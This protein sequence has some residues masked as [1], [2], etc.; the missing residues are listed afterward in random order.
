MRIVI[1][2]PLSL[3]QTREEL[4][5]LLAGIA[6]PEAEL[7]RPVANLNELEATMRVLADVCARAPAPARVH[8]VGSFLTHSGCSYRRLR[9]ISSY[10]LMDAT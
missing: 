3:A 1:F 9:C 8:A 7:S 6:A 10:V 5:A 4:E 2:R